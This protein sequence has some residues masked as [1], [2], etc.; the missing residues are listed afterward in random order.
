M[1]EQD[2][3]SSRYERTVNELAVFRDDP[4]LRQQ[5]QPH[6]EARNGRFFEVLEQILKHE[7][8]LLDFAGG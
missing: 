4:G 8:N 7:T 3:Y 2:E 1:K 5:H 6:F